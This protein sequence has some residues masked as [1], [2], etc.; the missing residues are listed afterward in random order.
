MGQP[1]HE[2]A[3][4]E[5]VHHLYPDGDIYWSFGN[6]LAQVVG[7][8]ARAN[9]A[10]INTYVGRSVRRYLERLE[11]MLREQGLTGRILNMQ[12][13][14]GVVHRD[15]VTPIATSSRGRQAA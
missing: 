13:N 11:T 8:Y 6:E 1:V 10:I 5:A 4:K 9:T 12:G 7:E 15:Y 2:N 14:G 3:V